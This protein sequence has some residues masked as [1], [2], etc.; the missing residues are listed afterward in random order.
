MFELS[1]LAEIEFAFVVGA[2]IDAAFAPRDDA[3][4]LGVD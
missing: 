4:H 3:Q 1:Y 2:E